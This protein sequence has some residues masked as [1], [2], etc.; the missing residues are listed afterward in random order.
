MSTAQ[1]IQAQP[2]TAQPVTL[3]MATAKP[4]PAPAS[5]PQESDWWD[6]AKQIGQAIWDSTPVGDLSKNAGQIQQWAAKKFA[7]QT[8]PGKDSQPRCP[9]YF[10]PWSLAGY[11]RHG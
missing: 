7:E 10:R 3:D 5:T 2:S 1:P 8:D 11:G 9:C 6:K 4:I